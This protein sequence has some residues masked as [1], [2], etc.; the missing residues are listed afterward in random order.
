MFYLNYPTGDG[1]LALVMPTILSGWPMAPPDIQSVFF[2]I[3][4]QGTGNR[5]P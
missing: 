3:N 2:D 5:K 1:C 4:L